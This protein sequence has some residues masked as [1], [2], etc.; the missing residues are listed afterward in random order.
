MRD[1]GVI[2]WSAVIDPLKEVASRISHDWLGSEARL[3]N[4]APVEESLCHPTDL[5]CFLQAAIV[6]G[7]RIV[8]ASRLQGR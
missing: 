1:Q 3:H 5:S 4:Q 6:D 2:V 8:P 7:Q